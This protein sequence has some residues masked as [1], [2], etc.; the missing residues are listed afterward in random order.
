MRIPPAIELTPDQ[1]S[2]LETQARSRSL[3]ARVVDRSRIVLL[4]AADKQ[5]K[6]LPQHST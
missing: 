3:P 2:I 5:D 1:Q 6:E 4:A